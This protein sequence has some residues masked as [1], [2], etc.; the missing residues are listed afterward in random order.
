MVY[1]HFHKLIIALIL[2]LFLLAIGLISISIYG[3]SPH[4]PQGMTLNGY[5]LHTMTYAQ[6]ITA[7]EELEKQL[8]KQ[9]VHLSLNVEDDTSLQA[10]ATEAGVYTNIASIRSEIEL[11]QTGRPWDKAKKRWHAKERYLKLI[12]Y[13]D[14]PTLTGLLETRWPKLEIESPV[15]AAREITEHDEIR[16]IT[17]QPGM[18]VHLSRLASTIE[19]TIQAQLIRN[20]LNPNL[21]S[22]QIMIPLK[23][24]PPEV[25]IES[26]KSQGIERKISEYSTRLSSQPEGRFHNIRA[27]AT[28]IDMMVLKPGELFDYEKVVETARNKYGFQ[29]AP[30]ILNGKLVPG[31]GGGICQVSSTLYNAVLLYGLEVVS[32]QN[33]SV[34]VSYVPM[35]QDAT[36]STG[37]INFQF[38]NNTDHS[39]L[40]HT[41]WNHNQLSVKLFGKRSP[42]LQYKIESKVVKTLPPP[43]QYVYNGSLAEGQQVVIQNG[44]EGYLVKTWRHTYENGKLTATE[45]ISED[46]YQPKPQ[47]IAVANQEGI[48]RKQEEPKKPIV[49]DGVSGPAFLSL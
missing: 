22:L 44:K 14:Q 3:N 10:S 12:V 21:S 7:L 37:Y 49:E 18:G 42:S 32:R 2:V 24:I 11:L 41:E 38:R 5:P 48:Q 19:Q 29:E 4:P 34:P 36:Y 27:T 13:I 9:T 20:P 45:E 39:V 28:V 25:T 40:I 6:I 23:E 35:G 15:N 1:L 30:V 33:H 16:Y 8:A 17:G 46:R 47:I 26:L 43:V 31:I